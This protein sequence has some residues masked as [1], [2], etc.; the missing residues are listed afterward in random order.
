MKKKL[1]LLGGALVAV[2]AGVAMMSAYEAHI[3]NVTAHIENALRIHPE[4]LAFGTVFPQEY[5][6][7]EFTVDLSDSFRDEPTA[8]DVQYVI[9][10]KPKCMCDGDPTDLTKCPEGKYAPVGYAT[11]VCPAGYTEMLSLCPYL[12][13]MD[14]D[15]GDEN[16]RGVSSYYVDD[17]KDYCV[18]R[19][20]TEE[21]TG[22]L[23][24]SKG[25]LLDSWI[26]DLKVPPVKGS[27]GQDWPADCP[28][29]EKDGA[30]YGCD[31]WVE[32][33]G[34]SRVA[35]PAPPKTD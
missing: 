35:P 8:D 22:Y 30:D 12:S 5:L 29:V 24:K 16:D 18:P 6:T 9:K 13:K 15:A 3:I 28:T 34:I 7:R 33:T 31:L 32:V 1:F 14:G 20:G 10:Q 11:H 27:V 21:A 19:T 17:T 25:D 2:V 26:V 4:A 23:A